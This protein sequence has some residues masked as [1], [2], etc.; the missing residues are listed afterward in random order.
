MDIVV[1]PAQ[2]FPKLSNALLAQV[3]CPLSFVSHAFLVEACEALLSSL[4]ALMV[5]NAH[6]SRCWLS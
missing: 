2:P 6:S 4:Q 1:M 3:L 5:L